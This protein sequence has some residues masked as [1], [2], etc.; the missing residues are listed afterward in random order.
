LLLC[1][2][3]AAAAAALAAGELPCPSCRA[4]RLAR[5][6][7]GRARVIRLLG[8]QAT[9]LRPARGRCRSCQATH[10]LVPS[11]CAPR[12][13]DGIEVIP[14][15]AGLALRGYGTARTGAQLGVPPG[16]ARGWLRRLRARAGDIRQ[17]AMRD[18]GHEGACRAEPIPAR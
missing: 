3:P 9:R 6:G 17:Q 16:T 5:W 11:W 14:V 12:R 18:L 15:A 13:A 7:H 1:A 8:G 2:D 10:V 4:G